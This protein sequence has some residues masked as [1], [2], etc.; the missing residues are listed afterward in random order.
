MSVIVAT[1]ASFQRDVLESKKPV[2]VDFW[3]SWCSPCMAMLPILERLAEE[4]GDAI[5]IVKINVNEDPYTAT[6]Y[7]VL[8]LPTMMIFARGRMIAVRT[9]AL[10]EPKLRSWIEESIRGQTD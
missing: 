7:H 3:A 2:L 9:Q 6:E 10:P 1:D 4:F 8:G 5:K